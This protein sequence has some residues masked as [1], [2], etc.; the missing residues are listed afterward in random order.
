GTLP[1]LDR[2]EVQVQGFR[3]RG[4]RRG[5]L[6]LCR[7][8]REQTA[9]QS[10]SLGFLLRLLRGR[11]GR[12]LSFYRLSFGC[13]GRH[14]DEVGFLCHRF[15]LGRLGFRALLDKQRLKNELA[16]TDVGTIDRCALRRSS[17]RL[18]LFQLSEHSRLPVMVV[19]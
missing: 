13:D 3:R 6:R 11:S 2:A 8:L 5:G 16:V 7:T 19:C 4:R 14:F 17:L 1:L 15:K 10:R 12:W 9:E 18:V